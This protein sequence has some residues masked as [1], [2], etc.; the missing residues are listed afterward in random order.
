MKRFE[1]VV[2]FHGHSCPGLALGYRVALAALKAMDMEKISEDEEL[3]AIVENDSCAVDA[4]Q[5]VTG[6]TFGKGNLIFK[7]YGKQAYTF[8]KRPSGNGIRISIDFTP[9]EE[10][11]KE[12]ELW[13]RYGRGDRSEEVVR[14]V[15]NRKARKTRAILESPEKALLKITKVKVPLPQ[16]ARIY[17]SLSCGMCGEKMAEPKARVKEGKIVCI[18]CFE[19]T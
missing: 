6:C 16:E 8:V 11:E 17:Q 15:H 13:R 3:V 9:P 12:K 18:P 14:A 1:E 7:D 4:I 5:A 19:R 2:S 10:T